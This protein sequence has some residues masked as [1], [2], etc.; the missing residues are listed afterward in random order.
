MDAISAAVARANLIEICDFAKPGEVL[1]FLQSHYPHFDQ[2]YFTMLPSE[3]AEKYYITVTQSHTTSMVVTDHNKLYEATQDNIPEYALFI[4]EYVNLCFLPRYLIGDTG[5]MSPLRC[6][7]CCLEG[8]Y[9]AKSIA[10]AFYLKIP[11]TVFGKKNIPFW[12]WAIPSEHDFLI[13]YSESGIVSTVYKRLGGDTVEGLAGFIVI[14]E[15][16]Y[17]AKQEEVPPEPV[18]AK[19]T[20]KAKSDTKAKPATKAKTPRKKASD[21]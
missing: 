9:S 1:E 10:R 20:T 4:N 14:P 18:K 13:V 8:D 15:G 6:F 19:H 7:S 12:Q 2:F 3:F 11:T 5:P 21:V 16:R 17:A